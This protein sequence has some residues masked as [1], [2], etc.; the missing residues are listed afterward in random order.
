MKDNFST[1]SDQYAKFRPHYP[2]ALYAFMTNLLRE[3]NQAWDCGTG[4]GQVASVLSRYFKAVYASDISKK[5]MEQAPVIE[6]IHYLT[7]TAGEP[8]FPDQFF[9]LITVAQ[10]IHWFDFDKFYK[11]VHRTLKPGGLMA[12]IGYGLTRVSPKVDK[13]IDHFYQNIVGPYWDPERKYLDEGYQTIPFPFEEINCPEFKIAEEWTL[14]HFIGYLK[15]WSAVKHFE[16]KNGFN[17]VDDFTQEL[18]SAWGTENIKRKVSFPLLTRIG[19]N[20]T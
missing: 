10:A 14:D 20:K 1:Q 3:K 6:N 7:L 2:E 9:D 11:E 12:V 15:T 5:Q 19:K 18:Q 4:N 13:A 17:P 8:Y 16:A